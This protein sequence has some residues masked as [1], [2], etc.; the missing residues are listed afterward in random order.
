MDVILMPSA[1]VVRGYLQGLAFAVIIF[2]ACEGT[3]DWYLR[4]SS[5]RENSLYKE[6]KIKIWATITKI[7]KTS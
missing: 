1:I 4:L 5:R 6:L 3:N 7:S 2:G